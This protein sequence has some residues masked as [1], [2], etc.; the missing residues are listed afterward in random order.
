MLAITDDV[1]VNELEDVLAN[2][3]DIPVAIVEVEEVDDVVSSV[4]PAATSAAAG[5]CATIS[6]ETT[7]LTG[8]FF[9]SILAT[10]LTTTFSYNTDLF[11]LAATGKYTVTF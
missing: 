5:S 10:K 3:V 8:A 7:E 1:L 9:G 4:L 11:E 6:L 2:D